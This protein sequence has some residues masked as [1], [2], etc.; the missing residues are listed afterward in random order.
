MI[1]TEDLYVYS[2]FS[3]ILSH[4]ALRVT[5]RFY[6]GMGMAPET[7][8][9]RFYSR[10]NER[11]SDFH[12]KVHGFSKNDTCYLLISKNYDFPLE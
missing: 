1:L 4:I 2:R 11:S 5:Q 9:N 8:R 3:G 10:E 7:V 12:E 6:S